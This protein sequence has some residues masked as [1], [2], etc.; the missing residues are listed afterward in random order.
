W[1]FDVTSGARQRV[2]TDGGYAAL[3]SADGRWLYLTR[4]DREGLWRRPVEGGAE[5]LVA[6]RV[7]AGQWPNWGVTPS[8]VYYLTWPDEGDP[9]VAIVDEGSLAPRLLAR[10]PEY[11]WPGIAFTR[12]GR[13]V[14]AR[15]ERRT[16]NI[17]ALQ[18][19]R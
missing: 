16:A 10:L 9:R 6:E 14:Y 3:E 4:L 11:G 5:S 18:M 2:T 13:I 17:G 7:R 19:S 1:R 12:D 8:G 15:A